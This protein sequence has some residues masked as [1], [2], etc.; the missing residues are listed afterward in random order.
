M[1]A[2]NLEVCFQLGFFIYV[3]VVL[4]GCFQNIGGWVNLFALVEWNMLERISFLVH[5]HPG[6]SWEGQARTFSMCH[7]IFAIKQIAGCQV[8]T[9]W[10]ICNLVLMSTCVLGPELN[11]SC[12]HKVSFFGL[13]QGKDRRWEARRFPW[14]P[15]SFCELRPVLGPALVCFHLY[16]MLLPY[17]LQG[18][19]LM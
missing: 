1:C 12:Q 17:L 14:L 2:W 18:L 16:R 3:M 8:P 10:L 13:V 19:L 9:V 7:M 15:G 6:L 4:L 11:F 5:G